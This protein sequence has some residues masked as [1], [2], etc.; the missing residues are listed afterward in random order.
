MKKALYSIILL[1]SVIILVFSLSACKDNKE[2]G[3]LEEIFLENAYRNPTRNF[4]VWDTVLYGIVK[5]ETNITLLLNC[6]CMD[7]TTEE[8]CF[9]DGKTVRIKDIRGYQMTTQTLFTVSAK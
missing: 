7:A 6:T 1:L 3:I 2:T 9:A 4:A 5:R 8:G